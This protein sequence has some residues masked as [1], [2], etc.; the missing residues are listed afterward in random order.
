MS[1][2]HIVGSTN[3]EIWDY[4]QKLSQML[5]DDGTREGG[6]VLMMAGIIELLTQIAIRLP[7]PR[8]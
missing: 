6:E 3:D 8:S 4:Y 5:K 7:E 1:R 2:P